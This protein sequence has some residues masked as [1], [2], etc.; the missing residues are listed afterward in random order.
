MTIGP[1]S[2]PRVFAPEETGSRVGVGPIL[3]IVSDQ[4]ATA[5]I[6][7]I[8]VGGL[9]VGYRQVG[10]G[11]TLVLLYGAFE[12]GRVWTRQR[13]DLSDEFTVIALDAPGFGASD[14]PPPTWTTA[15]YGNHLG[16][17][18]DVL[19]L[20]RPTVG[21]QSFGTVYALALYRQRPQAVGALVLVSAYAGC[22]GSLSA[23]ET[24][25]HV[26]QTERDMSA[27]VEQTIEKCCRPCS[28]QPHHRTSS[29][30][31]RR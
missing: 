23:K 24:E 30:S 11:P 6:Q 12:D 26:R 28:R 21:G 15:D 13:A 16:E 25:R 29:N 19:G 1:S 20:D 27:P 31:S 14:D 4:Q 8:E 2:R 18:L 9:T 10:S 5:E 22:A 3:G 17:I 7:L